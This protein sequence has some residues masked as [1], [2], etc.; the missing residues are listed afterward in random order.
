MC[1]SFWAW[2]SFRAISIRL[3]SFLINSRNPLL[4]NPLFNLFRTLSFKFGLLNFLLFYFSNASSR[5]NIWWFAL[6][7]TGLSSILFSTV[8]LSPL[9][10]YIIFFSKLNLER[11][12]Y[13]FLLPE[14]NLWNFWYS[15]SF[16][17]LLN[18]LIIFLH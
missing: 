4:A 7:T 2:S 10:C 17:V 18:S 15:D 12:F 9:S 11:M 1:F 3:D 8:D 13:S 14:I 5:T 16:L 6:L